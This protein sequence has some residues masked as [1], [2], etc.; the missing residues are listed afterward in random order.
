MTEYAK[1]AGF[2]S[3]NLHSGLNDWT[4]LQNVAAWDAKCVEKT[5]LQKQSNGFYTISMKTVYDYYSYNFPKMMAYLLPQDW[6][7]TPKSTT[8]AGCS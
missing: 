8:L 5:K 4:Y 3:F 2:N 1:Q 7:P 6:R